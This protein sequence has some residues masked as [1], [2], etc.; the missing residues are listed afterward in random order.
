MVGRSPQPEIAG[1]Q[2]YAKRPRPARRRRGY[3]R[4]L[5]PRERRGGRHHRRAG[6]PILRRP[7]LRPEEHTT[8]LQSLMRI[9]YADLRLKKKT[10]KHTTFPTYI[11]GSNYS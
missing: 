3:R 4:A 10:H 9:S 5:R 8:D 1:R 6:N 11:I 7:H 2:E